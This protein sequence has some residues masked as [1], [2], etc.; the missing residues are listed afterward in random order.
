MRFVA[1]EDGNLEVLE[2]PRISRRRIGGSREP[3][4]LESVAKKWLEFLKLQISLCVTLCVLAPLVGKMSF[5]A[6]EG[7]AFAR[8]SWQISL[9]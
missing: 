7:S 8:R 9:P 2:V 3:N 4:D 1:Q 6:I 5:F